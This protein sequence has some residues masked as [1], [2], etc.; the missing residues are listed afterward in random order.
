MGQAVRGAPRVSKEGAPRHC[1]RLI[2]QELERVSK[3]ITVTTEE[4]VPSGRLWE[5]DVGVKVWWKRRLYLVL[6]TL[7][8][9]LIFNH[10]H[11]SCN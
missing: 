10:R 11:V 8:F 2:K 3:F 7:L 9:F 4:T 6:N 1:S 5:A